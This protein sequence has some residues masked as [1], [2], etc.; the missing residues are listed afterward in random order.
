MMRPHIPSPRKWKKKEWVNAGVVVLMCAAFGIYAL[1][2]N[3][4][5]RTF[6]SSGTAQPSL[7]ISPASLTFGNQTVGTQSAAQTVTVTNSGTTAVT[8]STIG[9]TGSYVET[10]TCGTSLKAEGV[11]TISVMFRPAAAG[12]IKG[13]LGIKSSSTSAPQSIALTGTGSKAAV[14]TG[15]GNGGGIPC[16]STPMTQVPAD[17]TSELSYVNTAAGVQVSQLTDNGANRFYYF[18]VPAYS[19]PMNQIMYVDF[20][21]GNEVV[22]SNSN[23][24]SAQTISP[25][26]TGSQSFLSGDGLL[27]YY[28]KPNKNGAPGGLDIF[29][30]F[31]NK[32][33]VCEEIQLT[34]LDVAPMK[35]LPVWEISTASLD[36]AGGEDIAFSPDTLIHR[37]HV[38]TNG[39]SVALQTMTMND[40]ENNATFHRLRMNPI[41]SNIVMYKRNAPGGTTAQPE[42]WLADLN[43]C[44][45]GTCAVAGISNIVAKLVVPAGHVPK[46]GHINW[47]PDG[48]SIL[49]SEPDAADYWIARNVV[50]SDGTLNK[51]FML[52]QL[53]PFGKPALTA[54]YCAF[55]PNWPTATVLACLAGP[56][57][58]VH[59]NTFYLMSSDGK[60]AIKLL[61]ASDAPVLTIAG[62][63]MPQ[64]AQDGQ[65]LMFN[66]DRT[67]VPQIYLISGFTLS[68]P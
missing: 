42:T 20:A 15:G 1:T 68:V 26:M 27:A 67:G 32:T 11:C 56:A 33:G 2:P 13:S 58:P 4:E 8:I 36:A 5:Y 17:V 31:L 47:S 54:D 64:F 53:G 65:H 28:D 12:T 62:T 3:G 51:N 40:P 55:P 41:F 59:P 30:V 35:P 61:T 21:I 18:D 49:F 39:T 44:T 16:A 60:G 57:S 22:M 25:T 29:G 14:A 34:N 52:Q 48:L 46:A 38:E 43:A 63:P 45:N 66:S 6:F 19:A 23:G 7:S 9:V 10:N 50:N 37:I 24:T